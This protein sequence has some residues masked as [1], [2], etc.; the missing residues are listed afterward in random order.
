MI[1][2][3]LRYWYEQKLEYLPRLVIIAGALFASVMMGMVAFRL[4]D[5]AILLPL[6][7]IAAA[8]IL[9][10]LQSPQLGIAAM[11]LSSFLVPFSLG[12]GTQTRI[13]ITL[14]ILVLIFGLWL[15]DLIV[16]K[17]KFVYFPQLLP[18]I[19]LFVVAVLAFISGNTPWF[20]F[21]QHAPL[22]SQIGGLSVFILSIAC[23]LVISQRIWKILWLQIITWTFMFAAGILLVDQL[24]AAVRHT[25]M[26]LQIRG[27]GGSM[28]WTWV[29]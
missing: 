6:L 24:V 1:L 29:V 12:T 27:A 23:F 28:F 20:S 10:L 7:P 17:E 15:L 16:R 13:S 11:I 21:S 18:L 9:L 22:T 19:F 3:K 25:G 26:F 14:L 8:G 2:L 5:K 4:D